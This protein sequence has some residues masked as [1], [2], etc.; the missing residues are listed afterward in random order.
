MLGSGEA[1]IN[2]C[3]SLSYEYCV[4]GSSIGHACMKETC[5]ESLTS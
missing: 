5:V 4:G 1:P 2:N 3:V